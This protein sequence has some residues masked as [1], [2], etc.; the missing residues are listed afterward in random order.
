[1]VSGRSTTISGA[2]GIMRVM[3][4]PDPNKAS[5]AN[6]SEG[7]AND[8]TQ[9]GSGAS[10]ESAAM[11]EELA[12][13]VN[14]MKSSA[15]AK[16]ANMIAKAAGLNVDPGQVAVHLQ[17]L[18][19]K[20]AQPYIDRIEAE[21]ESRNGG[22]HWIL[23]NRANPQVGIDVPD[24]KKG[25]YRTVTKTEALERALAGLRHQSNMFVAI[26]G[27]T[28]IAGTMN[29]HAKTALSTAAKVNAQ[30]CLIKP[31]TFK[32]LNEAT[33]DIDAVLSA[34]DTASTVMDT[35]ALKE[36]QSNPS[37]ETAAAWGEKVGEVFAKLAPIGKVLGKVVPGGDV[38][39]GDLFLAPAAV[40]SQ[41]TQVLEAYIA[42]IDAMTHDCVPQ[43]QLLQEGESGAPEVC[44]E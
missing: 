6:R 11:K 13:T 33:E 22:H 38:I 14:S 29:G 43:G 40:I 32:T 24:G 26:Q 4:E 5:Y 37:F 20:R 16:S 42:K 39:G 1:M 41:F 25:T 10:S 30:V 34:I 15:I 31:E 36:F 23:P 12:K 3:R 8:P 7:K 9:Q 18:A 27:A 17:A 21:L 44:P 2:S 19:S 35:T 28:Q